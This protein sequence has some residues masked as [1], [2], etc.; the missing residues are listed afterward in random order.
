MM[1][2]LEQIIYGVYLII[3]FPTLCGLL[4][5]SIFIFIAYICFNDGCAFVK[6]GLSHSPLER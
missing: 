1:Q 2:L 6:G 4:T 5:I 3:I